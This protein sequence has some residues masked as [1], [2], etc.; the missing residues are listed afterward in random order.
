MFSKISKA[1]YIFPHWFSI[2]MYRKQV[3]QNTNFQQR[4]KLQKIKKVR[5]PKNYKRTLTF[6]SMEVILVDEVPTTEEKKLEE[7]AKS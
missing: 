1:E 7:K 4:Y 5:K 6:E 3:R 2:E